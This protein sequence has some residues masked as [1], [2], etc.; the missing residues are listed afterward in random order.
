MPLPEK[1]IK[2]DSDLLVISNEYVATIDEK[3][4]KIDNHGEPEFIRDVLPYF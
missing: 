3:N 2:E 1:D 4:V